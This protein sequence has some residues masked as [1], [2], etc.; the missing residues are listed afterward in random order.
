MSPL[1]G[2]ILKLLA[3]MVFAV[4]LALVKLAS[5]MIPT[6]QV[7]FARSFFALIPLLIMAMMQGNW[8][9]IYRV[10]YPWR[11][12]TR[13]A[14]GVGAMFC[15]FTALGLISLPEATAISFAAPLFTVILAATF[16]KEKVRAYRWSAVGIGFVG[17]FVILWPRLGAES[18]ELETL[19]VTLALVSSVFMASAAT[20]V[21]RL[22]KTETNASIIFFFTITATVLGLASMFWDHVWP[23]V[24]IMVIMV[25]VGLLG[26]VGQIL[27]TQAFRL[28]EASLLAT[29]D[30]VTLI[31]AVL[32]GFF[33]FNEVPGMSVL[34]GGSIVVAAGIFIIYRE[35]KIAS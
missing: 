9:D 14:V 23:D 13:A 32:I 22:T 29:L 24:T 31:W 19:G 11:H 35:R 2:I 4:M 15:W 30:Y 34:I 6:G 10:N 16:L 8:R 5:G 28:A 26:G 18:A 17:V 27:M 12:A 20:M 7:I 21:R 3:T 33:M 25:A 1:K